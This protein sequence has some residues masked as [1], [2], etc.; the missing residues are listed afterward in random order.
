MTDTLGEKYEFWS[1]KMKTLFKSQ[2]FWDLVEYGFVDLEDPDEEAE[3]RLKETKKKDSKALFLVQ[4]A[5][6]EIIFSRIVIAATSLEAWQILKKEFQG[7]SKVIT[8]KLQTYRREFETLSM[9]NVEYIQAYLFRVSSLVNQMKSYGEVIY[10]ETV[11]AKVLRSLTLKFE[12]I[13]A[14]IE[15]AHDLSNYSFDELMSSLQAHED[16]L[17]RS[18]EKNE[19]KAFQ[20]KVEMHE[21]TSRCGSGSGSGIGVFHEGGQGKGA[22]RSASNE[23]RQRKIFKCYYSNKPGCREAYCW[24]KQKDEN[25]QASFAEEPDEERT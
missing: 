14:A 2:D 23:E 19:E 5:V 1:I 8:V 4:Q 20:V 21:N 22:D 7:S 25:N 10:E 9:K 13:V 15:E 11:V 18:Y 3:E 6:H 16:R 17:L 24:K 12:H